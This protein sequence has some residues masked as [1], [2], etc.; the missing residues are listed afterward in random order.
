MTNI[1]GPF[2]QGD[3]RT[4]QMLKQNIKWYKTKDQ[5]VYGDVIKQHT[6]NLKEYFQKVA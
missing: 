6:G 3:F 4:M 5:A 1:K 2:D